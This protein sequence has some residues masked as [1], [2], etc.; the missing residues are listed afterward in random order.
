MPEAKVVPLLP[1][2]LLAVLALQLVALVALVQ[3]S[4]F[5]AATAK[6]SAACDGI[7]KASQPLALLSRANDVHASP[8]QALPRAC[9]AAPKETHPPS[10]KRLGACT[11]VLLAPHASLLALLQVAAVA[12]SSSVAAS[13]QGVQRVSH[14]CVQLAPTAAR[15]I[16]GGGGGGEGGGDGGG[17]G[18]GGEGGGGEGGG[19]GRFS[20][21]QRQL[22]AR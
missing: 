20:C 2:V 15:T 8:I 7:T 21:G 5:K 11:A 9:A 12:V 14:A 10:R 3:L 22:H 16:T 1:L 19:A 18:G 4:A 6:A 13:S 17:E